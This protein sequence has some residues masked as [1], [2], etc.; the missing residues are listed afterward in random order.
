[1]TAIEQL[2]IEDAMLAGHLAA[3]V[4]DDNAEHDTAGAWKKS[5][6]LVLERYLRTHA[7]FHVDEF[8]KFALPLGLPFG[9][10]AIGG[11]LLAAAHRGWMTKTDRVLP[12]NRSNGAGK[13]VWQSHLFEGGK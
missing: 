10:K 5:A 6:D 4:A 1:M 2:T 7:T 11:R 3:Q 12:S 9:G 8:W 13:P